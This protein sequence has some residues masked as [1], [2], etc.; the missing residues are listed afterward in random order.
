LSRF[1]AF[2]PT[3]DPSGNSVGA[4]VAVVSNIDPTISSSLTVLGT[5]NDAGTIQ[6]NSTTTDPTISRANRGTQ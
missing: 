1:V 4:I 2:A 6:A 5:A 3:I